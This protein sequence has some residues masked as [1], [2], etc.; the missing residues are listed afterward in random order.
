M[1]QTQLP[2][3]VTTFYDQLVFP[4]KSSHAA[5]SALVPD[6][7]GSKKVGDFGCGQSLFLERFRQLEY[8]AVFLDIRDHK[9]K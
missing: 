4:S 1:I 8:D 7:L 5:Y 2:E 6:E 9:E 3:H